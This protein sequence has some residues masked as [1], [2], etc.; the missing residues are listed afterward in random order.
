MSIALGAYSVGR[1]VSS[2][3]FFTPVTILKPL[4]LFA[5]GAS[6]LAGWLTNKRSFPDSPELEGTFCSLIVVKFGCFEQE[7]CLQANTN[8]CSKI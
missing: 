6:G 8:G 7:V 5:S 2:V 1:C 3:V 4:D